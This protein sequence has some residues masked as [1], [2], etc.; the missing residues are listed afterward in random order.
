MA[1]DAAIGAGDKRIAFAARLRVKPRRP[2]RAI[3]RFTEKELPQTDC[4]DHNDVHEKDS[5]ARE[6]DA[7]ASNIAAHGGRCR[8]P[9]PHGS[10]QEVAH[11]LRHNRAHT[12]QHKTKTS[13]HRPG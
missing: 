8:R 11:H 5:T 12:A 1:D 10:N 7:I 6:A 4:V 2:Q 3:K 9:L 13:R